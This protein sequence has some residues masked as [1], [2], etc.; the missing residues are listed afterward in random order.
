MIQGMI[1]KKC[2]EIPVL[3][4]SGDIAALVYRNNFWVK[5]D[6]A[7]QRSFTFPENKN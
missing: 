2:S 7:G 6:R 5:T 3:K 4:T 1:R